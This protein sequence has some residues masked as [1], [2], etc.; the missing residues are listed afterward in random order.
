MFGKGGCIVDRV[1]MSREGY[2]KLQS[3]LE[4][5][6]AKAP[7]LRKAIGDAREQGDLSENAAYHAAREELA[8][9]E[10]RI[11][12]LQGQLSSADIIEKS[13]VA[14]GAAVGTVVFGATVRV[15]DLDT[16]DRETYVL[17]G[18]GE[19]DLAANRILTTSP[20]G[21]AL[22]SHKI[23]DVVE[24]PVPRGKLRFRIEEIG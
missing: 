6:K 16:G 14:T 7:A 23:G 4:G 13:K 21:K 10:A 8:K 3:E 12:Q 5:L 22:I 17:V 1:A 19:V 24:V 2:R 20:V 11:G 9:L 15:K 18:P